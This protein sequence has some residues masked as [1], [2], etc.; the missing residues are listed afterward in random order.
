MY[1]RDVM[2]DDKT[3]DSQVGANIREIRTARGMTQ[4]QLAEM[5][6][7]QGITFRQQT[8][9]K[10]EA[11]Q[12][13]LRL[14]EADVVANALDVDLASL[15]DTRGTFTVTTELIHESRMA[16]E[17]YHRVHDTMTELLAA[18]AIVRRLL[19]EADREASEGKG[20]PLEPGIR[21]E[22][23]TALDFDLSKLATGIASEFEA[24]VPQQ[25][26]PIAEVK[27]RG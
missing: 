15:L 27:R 10:I 14:R 17:A 23:S 3:Y 8:V 9:V 1:C 24:E 7:K 26:A 12:R 21:V 6:S 5:V 20:P 11:G 16:L 25:A 19:A 2:E 4:A 13:P 22:A 18:Q